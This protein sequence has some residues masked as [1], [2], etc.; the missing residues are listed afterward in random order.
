MTATNDSIGGLDLR[1]KDDSNFPSLK[2]AEEK[3]SLDENLDQ[4]EAYGNSESIDIANSVP[5]KKKPEITNKDLFWDWE[6][7]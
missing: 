3:F 5:S 7:E 4:G 1:G 6:G 2:E